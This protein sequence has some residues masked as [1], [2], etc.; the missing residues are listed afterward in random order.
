ML[1]TAS[2]SRRADVEAAN[3]AK[4]LLNEELERRVVERTRQLSLANKN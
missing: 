4:D 2:R 3:R 1:S